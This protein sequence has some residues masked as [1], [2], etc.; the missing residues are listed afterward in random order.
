VNHSRTASLLLTGALL[1]GGA[2]GCAKDD[3]A[4][5][6]SGCG[7]AGAGSGSAAGS[8]SVTG[9]A[10]GRPLKVTVDEWNVKAPKVT[11]AGKV[12]LTVDNTG[13]DKHEIIVIEGVT[14]A[15]LESEAGGKLDESKLP[16]NA[17]LG[18]VEVE[19][20]GTCDGG[21][22]LKPGNYVLACNLTTKVNGK[23]VAHFMKGMSVEMKV[24]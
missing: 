7:A 9:K 18:E 4:A 5:V 22:T 16:K 14:L 8:A 3:G 17:K 2:A 10:S 6:R 11:K 20:G 12:L 1:V 19:A 15:N 21:F 24:V 23:D 13:K